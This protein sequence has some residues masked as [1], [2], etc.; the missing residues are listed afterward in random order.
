MDSSANAVKKLRWWSA[1]VLFVSIMPFV[2]LYLIWLPLTC[3]GYLKAAD[4]PE[5][6]HI[7]PKFTFC[8][9]KDSADASSG[10]SKS[11]VTA[12]AI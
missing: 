12:D 5:N 6:K 7:V 8:A 10:A 9:S 3:Y 4:I 11:S 1:V 2:W